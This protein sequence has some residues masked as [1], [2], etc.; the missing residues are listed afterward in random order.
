MHGLPLGRTLLHDEM[1][2][3]GKR[4]L[5]H[6]RLLYA[7]VQFKIQQQNMHI[8]FV[9]TLYPWFVEFLP[10]LGSQGCATCVFQKCLFNENFSN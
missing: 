10:A 2:K 8:P 9:Y 1:G 5:C 4:G 3:A 7:F 6:P